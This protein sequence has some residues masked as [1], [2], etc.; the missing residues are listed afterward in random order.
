[1]KDYILLDLGEF[2]GFDYYDGVVFD[3]FAEGLGTEVGG[4]GRYNHLIGRFGRDLP[5]TGFAFDVDRLFRALEGVAR[6]PLT[7]RADVLVL[8]RARH[9][10]RMFEVCRLLREA[11]LRVVQD[12]VTGSG[13]NG[14]WASVKQAV[15]SVEKA[16]IL[17][18]EPGTAPD[19]AIMVVDPHGNDRGRGTAAPLRR[20][21]KIQDL[22]THLF[23]AV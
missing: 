16:V 10:T 18:G 2:R 11:G 8:A 20:K 21:V 13:T 3:V 1:L 5:S 6:R 17:L 12:T 4:G 15:L 14:V 23:S 7:T 9:G 19:E 22:T